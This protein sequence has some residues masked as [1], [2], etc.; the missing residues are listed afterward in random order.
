MRDTVEAL[1]QQAE[2]IAQVEAAGEIKDIKHELIDDEEGN[3]HTID[4]KVIETGGKK[5]VIETDRMISGEG[6]IVKST[7]EIIE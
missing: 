6:E 1:R 7:T 2:K 3:L 4:K 5:I